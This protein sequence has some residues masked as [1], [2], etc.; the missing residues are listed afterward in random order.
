VLEAPNLV[1]LLPPVQE[2]EPPQELPSRLPDKADRLHR[3]L[4]QI[5]VDED[6]LYDP[7]DEELDE[8]GDGGVA[9]QGVGELE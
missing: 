3:A 1:R 6:R 2:H 7:R 4:F 8:D 5:A 9:G